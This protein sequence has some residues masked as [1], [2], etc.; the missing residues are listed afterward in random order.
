MSRFGRYIPAATQLLSFSW[1]LACAGCEPGKNDLPPPPSTSRSDAVVAKSA[2]APLEP[3]ATGAPKSSATAGISA[4]RQLCTNQS[5]KAAPKLK[6]WKAESAANAT[7]PTLP[8]A[9]GVGRWTWVNL[10][11]AWC[12][13]CK[14]E[15]P[16]IV[17][18][19]KKLDAAGTRVDVDFVSL[20]DDERQLTRFLESQPASGVRASYWLPEGDSRTA[21]MRALVGKD[22]AELPVQAFF[23]P[24]GQLACVVQGAIDERDEPQLTAMFSRK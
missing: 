5:A 19:Q 1:L 16:R 6:D 4:P 11:A 12:G 21:F 10:W 9:V 8:P 7:A 2:Q 17:E 14:E 15:M 13:P 24:N 18:M 22:T 23:A 3:M 20:D